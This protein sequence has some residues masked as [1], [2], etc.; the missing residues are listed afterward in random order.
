[1]QIEELHLRALTEALFPVSARNQK[2]LRKFI[3][4]YMEA[5]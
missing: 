5:T 4:A 3:P 1:M 2:S